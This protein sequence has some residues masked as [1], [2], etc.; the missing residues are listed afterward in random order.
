[1]R[2]MLITVPD[3]VK[4][5]LDRLRVEKGYS[6]NGFVRSA[7]IRALAAESLEVRKPKRGRR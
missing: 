7:I 5:Q 1:M 6:L 3:D 4:A 2:G